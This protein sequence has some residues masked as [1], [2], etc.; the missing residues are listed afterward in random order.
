MNLEEAKKL[1]TPEA[2]EKL[3][4][5]TSAHVEIDMSKKSC[6][7]I[8]MQALCDGVKNGVI[9]VSSLGDKTIKML[10]SPTNTLSEQKFNSILQEIQQKQPNIFCVI[11]IEDED[12]NRTMRWVFPSRSGYTFTSILDY[13]LETYEITAQSIRVK[14]SKVLKP[15]IVNNIAQTITKYIQLSNKDDANISIT[16]I[17]RLVAMENCYMKAEFVNGGNNEF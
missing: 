10:N 13:V 14:M 7:D 8:L 2:L 15:T 4:E 3:K 11:S 1:M 6:N 9:K 17:F 16:T 5:V 12:N